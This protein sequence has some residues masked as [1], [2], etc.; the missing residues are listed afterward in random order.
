MVYDEAARAQDAAR[1]GEPSGEHGGGTCFSWL[2]NTDRVDRRLGERSRARVGGRPVVDDVV[3]RDHQRHAAADRMSQRALMALDI[4]DRPSA[5]TS[6]R[7]DVN[8]QPI[9]KRTP[10]PDRRGVA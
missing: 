2:R 1:L 10:A 3:G 5:L 4:G 6:Y 8:M 9:G 7:R